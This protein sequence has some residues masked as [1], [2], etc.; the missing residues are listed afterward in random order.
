MKRY[1]QCIAFL[2]LGLLAM[3][4]MGCGIGADE[5]TYL[6]EYGVKRSDVSGHG[7]T[8]DGH[9]CASDQAC[10]SGRCLDPGSGR[11]VCAQECDQLRPC[12]AGFACVSGACMPQCQGDNDCDGYPTLPICVA[13][14]VCWR[15]GL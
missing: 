5:A 13:G 1:S 8:S 12:S 3:A 6:G 7:M 9:A 15:D 4:A 10:A 2:S 11:R 14:G